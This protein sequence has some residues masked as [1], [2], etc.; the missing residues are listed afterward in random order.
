MKLRPNAVSWNPMEPFTFT[1]ANEDY[2]CVIV[3]DF[4]SRNLKNKLSFLSYRFVL[5]YSQ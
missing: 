5:G 3:L 1:C 4:M 2:K